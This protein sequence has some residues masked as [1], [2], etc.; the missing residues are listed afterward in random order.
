MWNKG[1][2]SLEGQLCPREFREGTETTVLNLF[3]VTDTFE[4]LM[5]IFGASPQGTEIC[6]YR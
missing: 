3:W 1:T 2:T 4:N 6:S 5:K